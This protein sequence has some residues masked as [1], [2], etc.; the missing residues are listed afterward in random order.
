M[1][2]LWRCEVCGHVEADSGQ[3]LTHVWTKHAAQLLRENPWFYLPLWEMATRQRA[4]RRQVFGAG[5]S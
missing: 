4:L 3:L 2:I 5:V 1:N